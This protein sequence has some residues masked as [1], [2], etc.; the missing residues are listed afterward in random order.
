MTPSSSSDVSLIL[1]GEN[2]ARRVVNVGR[3]GCVKEVTLTAKVAV[4]RMSFILVN[5]IKKS[6]KLDVIYKRRT[7]MDRNGVTPQI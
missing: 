4:A 1:R 6:Q 2:I 5:Q 3:F 7:K